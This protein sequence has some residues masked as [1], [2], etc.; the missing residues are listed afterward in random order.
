MSKLVLTA[1]CADRPGLVSALAAAVAEAGGNWLESEMSR[2]AGSFAGIVLVDAPDPDA[3]RAAL[4]ALTGI[5]AVS[6]TDADP[7]DAPTGEPLHVYVLGHDRPGIVRELS[8]ALASL[9]VTIER[10]ETLTR[11]APMGD[12]VLFEADADVL[13]PAGVTS[14]AVRQAIEALAHDVVVDLDAPDPE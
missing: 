2:L 1:V 5:L 8:G 12:G 6:L 13:V 10:L 7:S 4:G 9:G 11:E 14:D 3:L